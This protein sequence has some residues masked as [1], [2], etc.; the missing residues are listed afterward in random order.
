MDVVAKAGLIS[1]GTRQSL[2]SNSLVIVVPRESPITALTCNDLVK[3]DIKKIALADPRTVPAGVYAQ[4]D[5]AKLGVWDQ[6]K[7]KVIST[8]NVR[9]ALAIVV[10]GNSDVGIV[11]KTDALSSKGVKVV[12]EVSAADGP[13][14]SYPVAL[15]KNSAGSAEAEKFLTYLESPA[16]AEVFRKYGFITKG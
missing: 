3:S 11:Y 5:L 7:E 14:I 13:R 9:A 2:L 4:A 10:S 6:V 1:E 8:E 12:G 15:L 16:A